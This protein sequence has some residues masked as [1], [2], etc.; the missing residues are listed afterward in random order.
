MPARLSLTN[1]ETSFS[2]MARFFSA[3]ERSSRSPSSWTETLA[4]S[5]LSRRTCSSLVA[6]IEVRLCRFLTVPNRSPRPPDSVS[7][8][9][10]R[11]R[12]MS[13]RFWPWPSRLAAPV[14]SRR[15]RE[16]SLLAPSGPEGDQQ[17][18]EALR[19]A[20]ELDRHCGAVRADA[21]AVGHLGTALVCREELDVAVAHQGGGHDGR[22]GVRGDGVLLVELEG[23]PGPCRRLGVTS[24]TSPTSTPRIRTSEPG[25]RPTARWNSPVTR[26]LSCRGQNA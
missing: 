9:L 24:V 12:F 25:K 15:E 10:D 14:S 13:W 1:V 19:D 7:S 22:L 17:V 23:R 21:G 2:A 11:S 5:L 18:V 8:A 26:T 16:P 20:V 4:R 3:A 6:S